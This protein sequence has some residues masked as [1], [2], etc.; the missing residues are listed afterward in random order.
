MFDILVV[1]IELG[2]MYY[3]YKKGFQS[4][5]ASLI[6]CI[7]ALISGI[8]LYSTISLI[9]NSTQLPVIIGGKTTDR[10]LENVMNYSTN[11]GTVH[12]IFGTLT[13]ENNKELVIGQI[14]VKFISFLIVFAAAYIVLRIIFKKTNIFARVR[15]SE[16]LNNPLGGAI[17]F[18][19][20]ALCV[21]I[22]SGILVITE[23]FFPADSV[24]IGIE[25]SEMA[26]VCYDDN[27]I[28]NIVAK[29]E[30]LFMGE[31]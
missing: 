5:F 15:V 9:L 2:F 28:V 16:Q 8:I 11:N 30:F 4:R 6:A 10:F 1:L 22:I 17:G 23:P 29:Q 21:Y 7:G 13:H 25:K 27:Y 14:A 20:G 19:S 31:D 26:R 3:G 12:Q 24:R 18:I